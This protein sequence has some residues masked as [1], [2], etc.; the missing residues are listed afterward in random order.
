M[1]LSFI[2]IH[3]AEDMREAWREVGRRKGVKGG[4]RY[5]LPH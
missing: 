5:R 2:H 4:E 1:S 3:E